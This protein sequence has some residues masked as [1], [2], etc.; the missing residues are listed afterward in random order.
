MESESSPKAFSIYVLVAIGALCLTL[1]GATGYVRYRIDGYE[2]A[3]VAPDSAFA[4][5]E[6]LYEKAVV[7]LGYSGFLGSAQ[8][9]MTLRDEAS[10]NDMRMNLK[11]AQEAATRLADKAPAPVRRDVRA[12][13]DIFSSL[14]TKAEGGISNADMLTAGT[15]LTTLDAR[16]HAALA[17]QR[18]QAHSAMRGWSLALTIMAWSGF[19][20]AAVL[21]GAAYYVFTTRQK[22]PLRVLTHGI[23]NLLDGDEDTPI[24]GVERTDA[25][26]DLARALERARI[27][28]TRMPDIALESD[29]GPIRATFRGGTR[30]L[31]QALM[32]NVSDQFE[33]IRKSGA[34]MSFATLAQGERMQAL[35]RQM[36]EALDNLRMRGDLQDDKMTRLSQTLIN[37]SEALSTARDSHIRQMESLWPQAQ[38]RLKAITEVTQLTGAKASQSLLSLVKTEGLL[39]ACADKHQDTSRHMGHAAEQMGERMV[40]ALN[41]VQA[42]GKV[43]G[44]VAQNVKNR[45]TD[46]VETLMH[47]ETKLQ[48]IATRAQ[49]RLDGTVNAEANM[50]ALAERTEI[51]A[52][53]MERAVGS[54]Y[55]RHEGLNEHV[56]TATHRMEAIVANFDAASRAMND[57]TAQVRRDGNLISNL[58]AELR[59]NNERLLT[60]IS[61]NDQA[62][63]SATQGLAEKSHA[64][65]QRL[66]LQIQQQGQTAET[67]I[68]T[69]AAHGQTMAGQAGSTTN[70]L[71]QAVTSLRNEQERLGETRRQFSDIMDDLATRFEKQAT[72]TF[73][74]TEAWAAQNFASLSNIS[75]QVDAVMQRL[76]MLGQL[77]GTLGAVAGQLGQLVP[78]LTRMQNEPACD[79]PTTNDASID[80]AAMRDL[81]EGQSDAM[82]GELQEHWH[83]AVVQIEAMHD[84]LAQIVVQQKDQLETRLIVMDKKIRQAALD[85]ENIRTSD[86]CREGNKGQNETVV[87][88]LIAAMNMITEQVADLDETIEDAD[89][90]KDATNG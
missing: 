17:T 7:A 9:Y 53:K 33:D 66:E 50:A 76:G 6:E 40:A 2:S 74:K 1:L 52:Q 67:H 20:I 19:L 82:V 18:M 25:L 85:I 45:M 42:S 16:L 75:E 26:G 57:A 29:E 27:T 68:A 83:K 4:P 47:S 8:K 14:L 81:L 35:M 70:A 37:A 38:E 51:S 11:T 84:Q 78:A 86:G 69:M 15:A 5:Q 21:G 56:I 87:D 58:L 63:F 46:A 34:E 12:I 88:D 30:N 77:T 10:L 31:F 59:A 44:D 64:L 48:D 32:A 62:N 43:L 73:G 60:S 71:A 72:S 89:P 36:V 22:E 3:L 65:L 39:R 54:I 13:I 28:F 80:T 23:E 49:K 79:A 24:W 41:I 90:K 55:D 61:Q